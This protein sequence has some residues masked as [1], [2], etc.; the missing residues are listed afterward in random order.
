LD[1]E[2][3]LE[4]LRR[5]TLGLRSAIHDLRH[6]TERPFV[7]AVESLVEV[8]RRLTPECKTGLIV[9]EG[10][11]QGLPGEV[12]VE[13]L[14]VLQEALTNA[15]RHS[16]ARSVVVTLKVAR[17]DLV[18]EVSDDGQGFELG[19]VPGVGLSSMQE[20]A[21]I[22]GGILEIESEVGQGTRV[23]LRVPVPQKG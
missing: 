5:A 21:A 8:N 1:I 10:F 13:L 19:A 9:E 22:I 6:E 17:S 16:G 20:R 4:A 3:E 23:R 2:E 18:A 14:R 12:G 15:R 11:P 7:T